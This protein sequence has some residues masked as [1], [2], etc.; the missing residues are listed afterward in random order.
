MT[1][2]TGVCPPKAM[3][4]HPGKKKPTPWKSTHFKMNQGNISQSIALKPRINRWGSKYWNGKWYPDVCWCLLLINWAGVLAFYILPVSFHFY[5]F[6]WAQEI[7]SSFLT[8]SLLC[9]CLPVQFH[10]NRRAQIIQ[11]GCD[12]HMSE[13]NLPSVNWRAFLT[14]SLMKVEVMDAV[15]DCMSKAWSGM[16]NV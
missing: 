11:Q 7:G 9:A 6:L 4:L 10:C 3:F 16:L 14:H 8:Q 15:N 12:D 2:H 13:F 1:R 5:Y